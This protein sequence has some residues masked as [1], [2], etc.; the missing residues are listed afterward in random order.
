MHGIVLKRMGHS[1]QILERS[2]SAI[3]IEQGAGLGVA[4][5]LEAFVREYDSVQE[6]YM[7]A[8][9]NACVVN[10]QGDLI[11]KGRPD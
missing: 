7:L 1:V 5:D 4:G 6:P 8:S 2:P 10:S 11:I 9:P 3:L